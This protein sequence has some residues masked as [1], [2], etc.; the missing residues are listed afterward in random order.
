MTPHLFDFKNVTEGDTQTKMVSSH[1][2][3]D[4]LGK[5]HMTPN[6][7]MCDLCPQLTVD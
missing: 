5:T 4:I 1:M 7:N 6:Y 3:Q 2:T